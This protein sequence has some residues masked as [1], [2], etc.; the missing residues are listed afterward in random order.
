[1]NKNENDTVSF[2]PKEWFVGGVEMIT[3]I[4][5]GLIA[6]LGVQL[7]DDVEIIQNSSADL[8]NRV[9]EMNVKMD[10]YSERIRQNEEE[11][12]ELRELYYDIKTDKQ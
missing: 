6:Y 9:I 11:V 2:T 1:M 4:L 8:L 7:M 12:R 5:L 3:K 10:G